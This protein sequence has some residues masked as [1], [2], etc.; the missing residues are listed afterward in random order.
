MGTGQSRPQ[1]SPPQCRGAP[2]P[3][4]ST[5]GREALSQ[6]DLVTTIKLLAGVTQRTALVQKGV[7]QLM[8][9][10]GGREAGQQGGRDGRELIP[11]D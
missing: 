4:Y 3:R 2:P 6:G 11:C 7:K 8:G 5:P 1:G 10:K 9:G